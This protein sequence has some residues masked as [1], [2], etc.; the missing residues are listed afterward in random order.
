MWVIL[1]GHMVSKTTLLVVLATGLAALS[2]LGC[3]GNKAREKGEWEAREGSNFVGNGRGGSDWESAYEQIDYNWVGV[4]HDL[5]INP[6][7]P[8]EQSCTCLSVEVGSPNEGKFVWRGTR[9]VI[10][11]SN[12]A[13]AISSAGIDCPGGS[14]NPGD[15]RPSISGVFRRNGDVYVEIEEAIGDRP[16]AS[17]AIIAPPDIRGRIYVQPRTKYL[18]YARPDVGNKLCRVR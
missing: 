6:T 5:G 18:P 17:G 11:N 15:R 13:V 1:T 16:I 14:K 3:G 2:S 10:N 7:R 8:R 9:P 12:I 4:R